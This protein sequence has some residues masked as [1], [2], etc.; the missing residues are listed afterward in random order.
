MNRFVTRRFSYYDSV[1]SRCSWVAPHPPEVAYRMGGWSGDCWWRVR[2]EHLQQTACVSPPGVGGA[3]EELQLVSLKPQL[4][5]VKPSS[6][7]GEKS[8]FNQVLLWVA[9]VAGSFGEARFTKC[10]GEELLH[11]SAAADDRFLI[12]C[13]CWGW[14]R[15][16]SSN[17]SR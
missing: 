12:K 8:F 7:A 15:T 16:L 11:P 5:L 2:S 6:S 13:L 1:I 14:G 17:S 4:V 3:G 9:I 10:W